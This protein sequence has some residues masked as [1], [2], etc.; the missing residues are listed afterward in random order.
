MPIL[1]KIRALYD[2][3]NSSRLARTICW[4]TISQAKE[5][6]L[7]GDSTR[8][9]AHAWIR[10]HMEQLDLAATE[11]ADAGSGL[12]N[13]LLD[14]YKPLVKRAYLIEYLAG[15][16][17]DKNTTVVPADLEQGIPL[18]DASVDLVTSSS[19]VEHLSTSGQE[20]FLREAHRVLRPGGRVIMSIS[21]IF[22][23][24]AMAL[25]LLSTDPALVRTGCTIRAR[26]D[27]R[28][29][30]EQ[31]PKLRSPLTPEWKYFPGFPG[32]VEDAIL[33]KPDT[34]LDNIGSYG[35]VRCLPETDALALKWAEIGLY[36]A[37]Q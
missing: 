24:D 29:M 14:W 27:L 10:R 9:W 37:K 25:Q 22:R 4:G 12:S 8:K 34:I 36:L 32:F 15:A 2:R 5:L 33:K 11:L 28:R 26:L 19:S 6:G 20:K 17:V 23:L 16:A 13:P 30:L 3:R 35:D 7:A 18:P 1:G 21:Y 31:A